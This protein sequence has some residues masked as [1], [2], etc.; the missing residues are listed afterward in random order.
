MHGEALG[1]GEAVRCAASGRGHREAWQREVLHREA[2]QREVLT[3][4]LADNREQKPLRCALILIA[5]VLVKDE[6][7]V[8]RPDEDVAVRAAKERRNEASLGGVDRTELVEVE[9]G[10]QIRAEGRGGSV[11]A[12]A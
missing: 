3:A 2:W 11:C 4:R 1:G 7:R 5:R 12:C 8:V 9:V 6:L 10:L